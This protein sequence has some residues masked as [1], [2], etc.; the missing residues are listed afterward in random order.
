MRAASQLSSLF[1]LS[2]LFGLFRRAAARQ[3]SEDA[4]WVERYEREEVREGRYMKKAL[5]GIVCLAAIVAAG[6]VLLPV[7]AVKL[8]VRLSKPRDDAGKQIP[9]AE[10]EP[11]GRFFTGQYKI[12]ERLS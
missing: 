5:T 4:L 6:V 1:R 10:G 9:R 8:A 11:S 3:N 2:G 12:E 7:A